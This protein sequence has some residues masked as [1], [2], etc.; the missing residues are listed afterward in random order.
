MAEASYLDQLKFQAADFNSLPGKFLKNIRLS[1]ILVVAIVLLGISSFILIPRT[2]NPEVKIPLIIVST[3]LPGAGP[4]EVEALVTIPLEDELR[5]IKGLTDYAS[6]SNE[7]LSLL[8]LEFASDIDP[9]FARDEVQ[10]A[11]E[12][13]TDLPDDALPPRISELDFESFPVITFALIKKN[14]PD[15]IGSLNR[16]GEFLKKGLEKLDLV[17]QV[18]IGG[19]EEEE[20]EILIKPEMIQ[21]KGINP[22][23]ISQSITQALKDFPAGKVM[24]S[25]SNFSL[26][27]DRPVEN[28]SDLRQLNLFL[29]GQSYRLE[30]IA[31]VA[32]KTKNN[33]S[34]AF[35]AQKDLPVQP[36]LIFSIFKN[37]QE[38]IDLAGKKVKEYLRDFSDTYQS[39]F[40]IRPIYDYSDLIE[41]Q[42]L[43]LGKNFSQTLLLVFFSMFLLYGIKQSLIASLAIPV[44]LLVVFIV[45]QFFGIS[46]N[47]VSI[48][49]LLIAL[50][51]FVDNAVVIIEA[52]TSYFKTGRF[53]PLQT[54]IL[55]W[56]DFFIELFLINLLTVWAFLPLLVTSGIIGEFIYPIPII[57]SVAM[58]GSAGVAFVFTLPSMMILTKLRLPKRVR[59]FFGLFIPFLI[60]SGLAIIIPKNI[61]F[62]PLFL[63]SLF[64]PA[65]IF[66]FQ[67]EIIRKVKNCCPGTLFHRFGKFLKRAFYQ[68]FVTLEPLS[69]KYRQVISRLISKPQ[70]RKRILL[71]IVI[72]VLFGYLLLPLGLVKNEFFPKSDQEFYYV[73]LELPVGTNKQTTGRE[74]LNL[75]KQLKTI[76]EVDFV[77]L[78]TSQ[79]ANLGG[80]SS[81]AG[82]N[83]AL[84]TLVLKPIKKRKKT[85]IQLAQETR[86]KLADYQTGIIQVLEES[87]GPP[88]GADLEIRLLGSDLAVL[89]DRA[90]KVEAFLKNLAGTE[91]VSRSVKSG[92]SKLSFVADPLKL[93]LY[94]LNEAEI[95]FWLRTLVSGFKIAETDFNGK[96]YELVIKLSPDT[97]LPERLTDLSIPTRQ[98]FVPVNQLGGFF[99]KP[100]PALIARKNG[101]RIIAVTASSLPGY[102]PADRNQKL[103][104]F[105]REELDLPLGYSWETGGLNEEN[106][107]SIQSILR[108]MIISG[109]LILGTMVIQLGSFRKA[110]IVI[111]VIPIAASAVL[112][113]FALT[114]TPISFPSLVGILA[115]FGIVIANSLMI[116]DKINQNLKAKLALRPALIDAA[117]SRLEPIL[118][119]T[120]S[121]VIGLIPITL[122]DPLWQG[123]GYAII[124]GMSVSGVL[125]LFFI[126][127]I[128]YYFFPNGK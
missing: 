50:A 120:A 40:E 67:K 92:T 38:R 44:S 83:N 59:V 78:E 51:L 68:G 105:S 2:L 87:G 22:L 24:T 79:K 1:L 91:N 60:A 64:L 69:L 123:M 54:A 75:G 99:L 77:I 18:L 109:I 17:G 42:F 4:E 88:A 23:L 110:I 48:Y 95:G 127:V 34:L 8:T 49:S 115:L 14:N 61:L 19:G 93:S 46:L 31:D 52:Y 41:E 89:E 58:I 29:A 73:Q 11:V 104:K 9:L 47:F 12:K 128:Y 100:N 116:V 43:D 86:K 107:E 119:T 57:V 70:A 28:L 96:D 81:P 80:N 84:A 125:M 56:K 32:I 55:V 39:E 113:I 30:E 20:I 85:S 10:A 35:L 121:Q 117:G 103:E 53:T 16:L 36:A 13:V 27:I 94:Q 124:A 37:P 111:L 76:P 122:S 66:L 6:S 108:A 72:F 26:S 74:I 101:R 63:L 114:R 65:M 25:K 3:V 106:Q 126:P 45:M 97:V 5:D 62:W 71:I 112:V 90:G 102:L 82:D 98:G 15:D 7:N 118:L 33:P 21:E